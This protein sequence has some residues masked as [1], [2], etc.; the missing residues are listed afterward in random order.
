M[1]Y[2]DGNLKEVMSV[3]K[4]HGCV[5]NALNEAPGFDPNLEERVLMTN[6]V[7]DMRD[8]SDTY[9]GDEQEGLGVYRC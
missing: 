1:I 9:L 4:S 6:G 3:I 7:Y 5:Q 8:T 2:Q